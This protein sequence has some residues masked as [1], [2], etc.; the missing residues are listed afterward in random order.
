MTAQHYDLVIVGAGTGNM[1]PAGQFAGWRIAV[2]EADRFGGTCLNRGCIPSK[3]LVHTADVAAVVR[4]ASRFGI[5][6]EWGGA[7]WPAI[8]DRV[9]GRIDPLPGL[10]AD[11]RRAGGVDVYLGEARFLSPKVLQVG[12]DELTA[13]HVVLAAG[14]RPH[15]PPLPGLAEVPYLTSD[16][17]MRLEK[18]PGSMVV[19][20]GGYVAAEISHIFGSL[21]TAV[22]IIERGDHLLGRHDADIAERFTE[23]YRKR[24]DVRLN[25]AVQQVS[26]AGPGVRLDLTTPTGPESAEGEVL[27]VAA[28][29]QPNSDRLD[30]AAAGIEVD[31]HGHVRTDGTRQTTT[32]GIWALGDLANHFQLKHMANAEARVVWHNIA[33]PD[34]PRSAVFPVVPAAVFAD[35]QVAS[36]GATERELRA[37]G[38]P[39]LAATHPYSKAAYGWALEDTTSFVK[40]LADPGTRLLLGAHIIG[41]Q[42]STLIQPLVQAMCLGSTVDQMGRGVLYIHPALTEVLEQA[43]LKLGG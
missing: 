8:R 35:P 18:L 17:V 23:L 5:K 30:V 1:L 39:Y 24:F 37:L 2:V 25:A 41:P 3:M 26:R 42:A 15:I 32:P 6:A 33:H 7:D 11:H 9:F 16:T 43:L 12:A 21:G 29:R 40:V 22:T 38:R 20:G 36:A 34:K 4:D 10:A 28:G 13:D 19:L 27:L 14:S 31:A